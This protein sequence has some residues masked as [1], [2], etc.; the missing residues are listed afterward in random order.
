MPN[1][2]ITRFFHVPVTI[3]SPSIPTFIQSRTDKIRAQHDRG[4][5]RKGFKLPQPK[6]RKHK[7]IVR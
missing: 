7:K 5:K 6:Q 3:K 2:Q 4:K 1:H